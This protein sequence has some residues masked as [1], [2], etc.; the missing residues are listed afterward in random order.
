VAKEP[1]KF[2]VGLEIHAR[3]KTKRKIFCSCPN[4]YGDEANANTCPVCLGLPGSL[5]VLNPEILTP[6]LKAALALGCHVEKTSEFSR[7]NYF[8]PDLPRNYQITQYDCPLA[9]GGGLA[10]EDASGKTVAVRLQRIHLEEDAGRSLRSKGQSVLVDMNRAGAPLL[11]IVTEPDLAN[12][13]QAR[14]WLGRLRQ[15]LRYLDVCD[16]DMENGS[17]RCDANVGIVGHSELSGPWVELKNLNSFKAV[18]LAVNHEI[19]R[20]GRG[21][22]EEKPLQR[23]TRSWDPSARETRVLRSKEL[24]ADYRYFPEPDIPV[25]RVEKD[26][27]AEIEASLPE[28][29]SAK[30]KRFCS[31]YGVPRADAVTLCRS[32]ALGGYFES[33]LNALAGI[34]KTPAGILGKTVSG[35]VLTSVLGAVSGQ[36]EDL[37]GIQL[38]PEKLAE[39]LGLL[40]TGEIHRTKARLLVERILDHGSSTSLSDL[41]VMLGKEDEREITPMNELCDE[42]IAA[43]PDMV[44][45]YLKGKTGLLNF[46]VGEVLTRA[47][48]SLE[49]GVVRKRLSERLSPKADEKHNNE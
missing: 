30:E 5:P 13:E 14:S 38:S 29:P 34:T 23:E 45:N 2:S 32:L 33:C 19:N 43:H 17:L 25:L 41:V 40:H 37:P 26:L 49:A 39:I 24:A 9:L 44:A 3:L 12:G 7:K 28:L 22:A 27:L 1:V 31:E 21:L 18:G 48:G 47:G 42:V 20:L 15:V 36:D 6:S 35:W 4:R 8:Y 10:T 11:E 46:F 16:G